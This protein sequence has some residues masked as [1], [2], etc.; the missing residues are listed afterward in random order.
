MSKSITIIFNANTIIGVS[1]CLLLM[2]WL[3]EITHFCILKM[4]FI[5]LFILN[6]K[7]SK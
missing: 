4:Y 6:Q 1:E 2:Q 3:V 7:I 5:Y